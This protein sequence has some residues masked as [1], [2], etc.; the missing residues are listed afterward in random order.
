MNTIRLSNGKHEIITDCTVEAHSS[1]LENN[2]G[3]AAF[4]ELGDVLVILIKNTRIL[5]DRVEK[6]N[7][8]YIAMEEEKYERGQVLI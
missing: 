1:K 7:Y 6:T 3:S 4:I 5:N 2:G 8:M